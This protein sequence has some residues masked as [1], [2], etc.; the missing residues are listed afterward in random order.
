MSFPVYTVE[1]LG[2]PNHVAIFVENGSNGSGTLYHVVGNILQGMTF[3][4]KN[5]TPDQSATYVKGSKR[6]IGHVGS[7]QLGQFETVC[8]SVPVPGA[9]MTLSGKSKN[10]SRPLRRCGEWVNEVKSKLIAE[11][12]VKCEF[13]VCLEESHSIDLRYRKFREH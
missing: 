10:P 3:E 9:Q 1:Y 12:L 4:K 11:A 13:D 7:D 2:S 5:D 8:R 6:L